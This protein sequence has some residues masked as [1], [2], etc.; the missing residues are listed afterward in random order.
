MNAKENAASKI[1]ELY[2]N[3]YIDTKDGK[4]YV[5]EDNDGE[6]VQLT[7][8]LSKPKEAITQAAKVTDNVRHVAISQEEKNEIIDLMER[9][10]L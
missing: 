3:D 7:I 10:G 9:L 5:W 6:R 8:S 4:I 1:K 2:G